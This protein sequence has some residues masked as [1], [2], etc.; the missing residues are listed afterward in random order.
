[1]PE[2]RELAYDVVDVFAER[3]FAGNQLAVVHGA[4]D[5]SDAQLLALAREFGFSETAFPGEA[6]ETSYPVRIFTPGGEIPFAG[7]PTLGTAW[8]LRARGLVAGAELT[9]ACG[10]G[11]IDVR[12]ASDAPDDLVELT[13]TPRDL[14]GPLPDDAV[15]ALLDDLGLDHADRAGEAWVAGAGL[16][17]VHLPVVTDAVARARPAQ[18]SVGHLAHGWELSAPLEG[19]NLVAVEGEAPALR[20]H[21]RVFV[22]GLSVAEDPATGSAAAG[23]GIALVATGL[24]PEGGSYE[25]TQGV[26]M[27]RPSRLFGRVEVAFGVASRVHVA[28]QVFR[29][30]SGSIAAPPA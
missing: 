28:G 15:A 24:L 3:P 6:D 26:E 29:V 18:A 20:V 10:A 23:L 8:V 19:V 12:F 11:D 30:A 17:F 7:H 4:S 22:P 2:L 25:I 14:A 9:Q 21:A 16:D 27:G 13:A 1:M 5:L